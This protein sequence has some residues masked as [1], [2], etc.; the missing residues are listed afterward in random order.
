MYRDLDRTANQEPQRALRWLAGIQN[1]DGAW[2]GDRGCPSSVEETALATEA[3]LACPDQFP[4]AVSAGIAWLH[5]SVQ[6]EWFR[7]PAPIGLYFT[8]LWYYERLPAD[9]HGVG[10][11]REPTIIRLNHS[12]ESGVAAAPHSDDTHLNRCPR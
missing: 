12:P 10:P 4:A 2:G 3:L 7:Q 11:W 8:K 6:N 1:A 5:Q 9:L